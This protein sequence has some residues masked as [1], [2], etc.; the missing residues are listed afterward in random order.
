MESPAE[1]RSLHCS[2]ARRGAEPRLLVLLAHLCLAKQ[3]PVQVV[4]RTEEARV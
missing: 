1:G 3:A 2:G 4:I